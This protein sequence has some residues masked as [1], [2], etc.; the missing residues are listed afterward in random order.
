MEGGCSLT[1]KELYKMGDPNQVVW[2]QFPVL[3]LG[4]QVQE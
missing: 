2:G 3:D 1:T 4:I